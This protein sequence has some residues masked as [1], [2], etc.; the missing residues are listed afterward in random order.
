MLPEAF[1]SLT[2]RCVAALP[3]LFGRKDRVQK[4]MWRNTCPE[5]DYYRHS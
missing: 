2:T 1:A 5:V 3:L 4:R